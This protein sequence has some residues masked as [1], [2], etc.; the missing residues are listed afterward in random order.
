MADQS[1]GDSPTGW[2]AWFPFGKQDLPGWRFDVITL[3]AI[4]GESSVAG[5]A[6]TLTASTLCLLPRIIPAPQA[7]LRP[8]RPQRLPDVTAKMAGVYNGVVLDSV[9]FFTNIM[10]PLDQFKP[11]AFKVL[12]IK[13]APHLITPSGGLKQK[14][15]NGRRKR[16]LE[17]L[18]EGW[19]TL[20]GKKGKGKSN[21]EG[22]G[23]EN[24]GVL[25]SSAPHVVDVELG[26]EDASSPPPAADR[27][28]P[29]TNNTAPTP[30]KRTLTIS[31]RITDMITYPTMINTEEFYTVPPRFWSPVHILSVFS[32]LNTIGIMVSA[33][34][35]KDGTAI[36][37]IGLIS[38]AGSVVCYASWWRPILMHRRTTNKVPRGDVVIRTR[39]GAFLVV[40]CTEEV[41]RELYSGTEECRYVAGPLA[42]RALMGLGMV[43]IMMAV[44]LMGN[45]SWESQA[46]IGGS[47]ILLNA[48]Y[49]LMSLLPDRT[50]WDLSRY[51]ITDVTPQDAARAHETTDPD[52]PR[53]GVP[54]FTR[55]LWYAVR[56]TKH[57]AWVERSGAMPG[58]AQ[59][60]KWLAEAMQAAKDNNNEWQAVS[61]KNAIMKEA[62]DTWAQHA[63][64]REG[65]DEAWQRAPLT[66][67]QHFRR[68]GTAPSTF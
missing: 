6:Q 27:A 9:G 21:L 26:K 8:T 37:A 28:D 12:E 44:V 41:A 13:H 49:W 19:E 3:L 60:K 30:P 67:V 52:D 40:K 29:G 20:A 46:L 63:T 10:H 24:E 34:Y 50:F 43:L 1:G 42:H 22:P 65:D 18:R 55:T 39:E 25:M 61:R 53:E 59:W 17:G 14:P 48:L 33:G 7:L 64:G 58:T 54:S 51:T 66:E 35:W 11:F 38:V 45:C 31:E 23:E 5:H 32:F 2:L 47:Y 4:I 57:D 68:T 56:E 16:W 36:V 62:P 15:G